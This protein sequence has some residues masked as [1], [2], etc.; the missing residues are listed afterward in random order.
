MTTPSVSVQKFV[1]SDDY[2]AY[3][4]DVVMHKDI[5]V[6]HSLHVEYSNVKA[7]QDFLQSLK[8]SKQGSRA[9]L[10]LTDTY[11]NGSILKLQDTTLQIC[12]EN[13]PHGVSS[14]IIL[15]ASLAVSAFERLINMMNDTDND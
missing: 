6:S 13:E 14:N 9:T 8:E 12:A 11:H 7:M 5:S 3:S 10:R 4:F 15:P 2:V 1:V